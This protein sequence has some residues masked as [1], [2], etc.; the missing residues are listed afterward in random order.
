MYGRLH[1][2][3]CHGRSRCFLLGVSMA[4][5]FRFPVDAPRNCFH[6]R[7]VADQE[8]DKSR[9]GQIS[10]SEFLEFCKRTEL[11]GTADKASEAS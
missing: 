7:T 3:H 9:N 5:S 1:L 2:W 11:F 6:C 10:F 8:V 4:E